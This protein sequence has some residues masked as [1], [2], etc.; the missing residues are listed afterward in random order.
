MSGRSLLFGSGEYRLCV[1]S[2]NSAEAA[3]VA[4]CHRHLATVSK[5]DLNL[6]AAAWWQSIA[7]NPEA[8][9]R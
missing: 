7:D 1:E 8:A 6:A 5:R 2:L 9:Q 3:D 4:T